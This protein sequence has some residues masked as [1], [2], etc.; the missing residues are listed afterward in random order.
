MTETLVSAREYFKDRE[1]LDYNQTPST[2]VAK[3]SSAERMAILKNKVDQQA[4][5]Q[6]RR[7]HQVEVLTRDVHDLFKDTDESKTVDSTKKS[8]D[9]E[10]VATVGRKQIDSISDTGVQDAIEEAKKQLVAVSSSSR[11]K[12]SADINTYSG[13]EDAEKEL[14]ELGWSRGLI[15]QVLDMHHD[16][17]RRGERTLADVGDMLFKNSELPEESRDEFISSLRALDSRL[18]AISLKN[19]IAPKPK[20]GSK[21]PETVNE[22]LQ[23][24]QINRMISE[25]QAILG[26]QIIRL[27]RMSGMTIDAA[28]GYVHTAI[29]EALNEL[30]IARSRIRREG[31]ENPETSETI[32][33][34]I[35]TL[36]EVNV[37]RDLRE[38]VLRSISSV[39]GKLDQ[40]T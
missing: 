39:K 30:E 4:A 24:V 19:R 32:N 29:G 34:A 25:T 10:V 9:T 15:D 33:G 22:V 36:R 6:E 31:S 13:Y 21:E 11:E 23:D 3:V 26:G 14:K 37:Y 17:S 16:L 1:G 40:L 12:D 5:M 35:K 7:R 20:D 28:A 38:D 27:Q 8:L 2:E 18:T